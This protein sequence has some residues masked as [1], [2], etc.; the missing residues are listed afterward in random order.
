VA[1]E[2]V[3]SPTDIT[4]DVIRDVAPLMGLAASASAPS[5]TRGL[6]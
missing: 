5:T 1:E 3:E 4:E 2:D 6:D